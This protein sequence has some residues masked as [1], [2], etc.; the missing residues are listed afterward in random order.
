VI[1]A[2]SLGTLLI[3]G[4]MRWESRVPAPM[5]PPRLLRVRAFTAANAT[6]FLSMAAITSAAF[7]MSQFFQLGLGYSPFATGLRF[8]P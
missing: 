6:G 7:L 1:A 4:F 2:L 8:L 5:L 3:A